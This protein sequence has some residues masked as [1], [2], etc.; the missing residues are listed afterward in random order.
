[1]RTARLAAIGLA[2]FLLL[3]FALT[4]T[5]H[6]YAQ[7]IQ[8]V[9]RPFAP[10]PV[11]DVVKFD[12]ALNALLLAPC[13]FLV[14][15]VTR[16]RVRLPG[17]LA[18]AAAV[19]ATIEL[20]QLLFFTRRHAQWRDFVL[21]VASAALGYAA[22]RTSMRRRNIAVRPS[23]TAATASGTAMAN[24]SDEASRGGAWPATS[25]SSDRA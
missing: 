18:I 12:H 15:L 10:Q 17:T 9:L 20:G 8:D 6:P 22:Y 23:A 24:G 25:A 5:N 7:E 14:P 11:R 19:S 3:L 16:R 1:M 4:L 21:N 13:G 2:G